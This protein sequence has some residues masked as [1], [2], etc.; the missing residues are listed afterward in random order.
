MI[1]N[2]KE[3]THLNNNPFLKVLI[4]NYIKQ[5]YEDNADLSDE[6]LLAELH[7]LLITNNL[8]AIFVTESQSNY[9]L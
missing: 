8:Q 1:T 7:N 5:Q 2:L 3:I 4:I 9:Y 6:A